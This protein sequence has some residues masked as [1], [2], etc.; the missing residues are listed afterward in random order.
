[1]AWHKVSVQQIFAGNNYCFTVFIE[2]TDRGRSIHIT[3][4]SENMTWN[5]GA[6]LQGTI[7][8]RRGDSDGFL[9]SK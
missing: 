1:M 8:R 5:P 6:I 2:R 7:R 4:A 3:Q 9:A